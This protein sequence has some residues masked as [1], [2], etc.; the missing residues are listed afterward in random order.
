MLNG[1]VAVPVGSQL[2]RRRSCRHDDVSM[3]GLDGHS[4]SRHPY[5]RDLRALFGC[6]LMEFGDFAM[7]RG[8]KQR[9]ETLNRMPRRLEART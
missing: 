1:P 9:A 3:T 5:H 7:L 6:V 4:R 2:R 8:I